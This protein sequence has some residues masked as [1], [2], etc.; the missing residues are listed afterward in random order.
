MESIA[1]QDQITFLGMWNDVQKR[2]L[3]SLKTN[4][5]NYFAKRYQLV[6]VNESLRL[7]D[8][9]NTDAGKTTAPSAQYRGFT[10]DLGWWGSDLAAIHI[11]DLRLYVSAPQ[12]GLTF[13]V[14]N[15]FSNH[16]GREID[17]FTANVVA[18]WNVIKVRKTYC[19]SSTN[20]TPFKIFIGYD[21][22]SVESVFM[23][24]NGVM[25]GGPYYDILNLQWTPLSPYQGILRAASW[26][27]AGDNN[28]TEGVNLYGLSGS[29]SVVCSW[30]SILC[31]NR[32]R[33]TTV[34]WYQLGYELMTER[35]Y[36]DRI[37]RY[38]TIDMT[39]AKELR[40]E[41][42]QRLDEEMMNVFDGID[43]TTW[44]GCTKCNAQVRL[45]T[46]LP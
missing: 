6:T 28:L 22:T 1:D 13:K 2:S 20:N 38:T 4:V 34:L 37:N 42:K 40:Q 21:A 44:D 19:D 18:G 12:S 35:I 41:F 32:D 17:S 29:V 24:L 10:F 16:E 43:L 7:P 25:N 26:E 36:S 14:F 8:Y 27:K 9:Y 3:K 5:T 31:N 33:F 46:S 45:E 11:E 30:D 23:P 39:R 15:V